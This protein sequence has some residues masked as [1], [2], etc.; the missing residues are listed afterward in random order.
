ME[1]LPQVA[2]QA[3]GSF[4]I[5]HCIHAKM[6]IGGIA[7]FDRVVYS[8]NEADRVAQAFIVLNSDGSLVLEGAPV[9]EASAIRLIGFGF[10]REES[11]GTSD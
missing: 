7:V 11:P 3:R 6:S 5:E 10:L 4:D 1:S 2:V 8:T 9:N